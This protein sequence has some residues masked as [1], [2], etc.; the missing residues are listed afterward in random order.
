MG[1]H[2]ALKGQAELAKNRDMGLS[3]TDSAKFD[4]RIKARQIHY[5]DRCRAFGAPAVK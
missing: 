4:E 2:P 1:V 5:S 3:S